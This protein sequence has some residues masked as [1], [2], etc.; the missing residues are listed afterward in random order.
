MAEAINEAIIG[1]VAIKGEAWDLQTTVV[2]AEQ[3]LREAR[4]AEDS[5]RVEHQGL[6]ERATQA[7]RA[8]ESA[9]GGLGAKGS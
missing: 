8:I 6:V 5:L 3:E 7:T 4:A 2:M 1:H 9:L